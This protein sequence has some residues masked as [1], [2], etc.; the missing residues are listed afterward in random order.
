MPG[1][2]CIP[3]RPRT[4]FPT[5]GG[6]HK[7]ALHYIRKSEDDSWN[8]VLFLAQTD[9]QDVYDS[10]YSRQRIAHHIQLKLAS[11]GLLLYIQNFAGRREAEYDPCFAAEGNSRVFARLF[12]KPELPC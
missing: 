12:R 11:L 10:R 7:R 3:V 5:R 8:K 9:R 4:N 2:R 6:H 1:D